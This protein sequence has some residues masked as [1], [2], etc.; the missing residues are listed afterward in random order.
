MNRTASYIIPQEARKDIAWWGRFS[1]MFYGIAFMWLL[2]KPETDQV[3]ATDAC[4][5]GYGG[6]LGQEYFRGR[7]SIEYQKSNIAILELLGVMVALKIWG[8]KLQGMYFWVH[9]DN[10]AVATILNTGASREPQLQD[11]LRE[12]ALLAA[13]N[14]FVIK[15]RHISGISNRIPD[16]LSRWHQAEHRKQFRNHA[17]DRGLKRIRVREDVLKLEHKW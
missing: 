13:K 6:I 1:H 15:A 9:V 17:R 7:F 10:E 12:I 11:I 3:I 4:K 8:G 5:R 14:N 2:K 16:W